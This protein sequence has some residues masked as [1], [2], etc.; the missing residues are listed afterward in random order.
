[1]TTRVTHVITD[2]SACRCFDASERTSASAS[3]ALASIR[4]VILPPSQVARRVSN[5]APVR[6][7]TISSPLPRAHTPIAGRGVALSGIAFHHGRTLAGKYSHSPEWVRLPNSWYHRACSTAV[8]SPV[9]RQPRPLLPPSPCWPY[10]R[11]AEP[12]HPDLPQQVTGLLGHP[13]TR[14]VGT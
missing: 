6:S 2:A 11:S 10:T 9:L 4:P 5:T 13:R 12:R 3:R 1:M 8:S 7:K 14:G